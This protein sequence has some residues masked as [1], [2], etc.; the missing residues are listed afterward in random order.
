[1]AT[2]QLVFQST[3]TVNKPKTMPILAT[4][5]GRVSLGSQFRQLTRSSDYDCSQ[6]WLPS[7]IE[8]SSMH[9][10][11]GA[12]STQPTPS[13]LSLSPIL[14]LSMVE[15]LSGDLAA[16]RTDAKANTAKEKAQ[17]NCPVGN[18]PMKLPLRPAGHAPLWYLIANK[19]VRAC[20]CP[21]VCVCVCVSRWN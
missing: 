15:S 11:K 18:R 17:P 13:P 10:L 6:L 9:W 1:M 8:G 19:R 4:W 16:A 20:L 5:E 21:C 7:R 2:F 14:S 3:D 12:D